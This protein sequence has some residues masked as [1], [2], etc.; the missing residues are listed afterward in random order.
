MPTQSLRPIVRV[1]VLAGLLA[2]ALGPVGLAQADAVVTAPCTG[3]KLDDALAGPS[4]TITFACGPDPVTLTIVHN[5]GYNV[6]PGK[7]FTIDGGNKV[8]LTGGG[9]YR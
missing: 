6:A 1:L 8:T 4:G 7:A 3:Q 5:G 9:A 2:A